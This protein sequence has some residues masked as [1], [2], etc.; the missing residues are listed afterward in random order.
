MRVL[1]VLAIGIF[2][3]ALAFPASADAADPIGPNRYEQADT[4][5]VKTGAWSDFS[6]TTA[7]GGSYGRSSSSNA[8]ATIYFT[9]TRLDW[10]AMT[11]ITPGIVDVY[12]DDVWQKKI[13]LYSPTARYR[14]V[15]WSSG[16]IADGPHKVELRRSTSSAAGEYLTLDAVDIWGTI[17]G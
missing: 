8:S 12:L 11:G 2:A 7:S 6:K 17:A 1:Y 5:I 4:H 9:G 3:C 13:D 14:V 15:A 10:I 16:T